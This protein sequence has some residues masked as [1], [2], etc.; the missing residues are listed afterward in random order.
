[1]SALLERARAALAPAYRVDGVLGVGGVGEVFRA[2]DVQL[3]RPVAVKVLRPEVATAVAV[4]R[5]VREAR[6]LARLAHPHIV[7]V[8]SAGESQGLYYFVMELQAGET[9][10]TRLER[11]PLPPAEAVAV[12]RQLLAA[13]GAAHGADVI[14]RDV[15]PSNVFLAPGGA[16]LGDFGIAHDD[17][18]PGLT[19]TGD[20]MGTVAYMAPEQRAGLPATPRT[21]L[22]GVGA[23]LYECLTGRRWVATQGDWSLVPERVKPVL[24]RALEHDAGAR[25]PGARAF[26][27]A[28]ERAAM[29]PDEPGVAQGKRR[30]WLTAAAILLVPALIVA[31]A[32]VL[33]RDRTR[34][35]EV[36]AGVPVAAAAV[37]V[38]AVVALLPFAADSSDPA[39]AVGR[40]LRRRLAEAGVAL[41]ADS[42]GGAA[43]L[44]LVPLV[45]RGD[46]GLAVRLSARGAR[47]EMRD[48]HVE[49]RG[50]PARPE[51]LGDSLA[52]DALLELW[53][54]ENSDSLPREALP[55]RLG[56]LI[57]WAAAERHFARAEWGDAAQ[58][59]SK[60]AHEDPACLICEWRLQLIARWDQATGGPE[61]LQRLAARA[62]RFPDPFRS[63]IRA[64]AQPFPARIDSLE[65]VRDR[66]PRDHLA[67]FLLGDE[68][69]HRGPLA[70]RPRRAALEAFATAAALRP[71]F[72]PAFE[73]TAWLEIADGDT[74]AARQSFARYAAN[75]NDDPLA[76]GIA[77]LLQ[78]ALTWRFAGP[79][80]G[81]A[82]FDT[83]LNHPLL[84][85]SPRI[86]T[87][88][89]FLVSFGVPDAALELAGRFLADP[90]FAAHRSAAARARAFAFAAQGRPDS[91][92]AAFATLA[93]P[94]EAA[95]WQALL[96]AALSAAD[97][98]DPDAVRLAAEYRPTLAALAADHRAPAGLPGQAALLLA[99]LGDAPARVPAGPS[100]LLAEADA[101]ARAGDPTG[102][103]ARTES[104]LGIESLPGTFLRAFLHLRRGEWRMSLGDAEQARREWVWHENLDV[105]GDLRGPPV[106]A[107]VD[108]ALGTLARWRRAQA[109]RHRTNLRDDACRD[110]AEVARL[111]TGGNATARA[112]ADSAR[113]ARRAL[114]C[115]AA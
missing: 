3:A 85:Q 69:M 43:D 30:A 105:E 110:Y 40:R 41:G 18:D 13:L 112:R 115:G 96:A 90:A 6:L 91:A 5:F 79:V 76:L 2:T 10:A 75:L 51:A 107:E 99:L 83:L 59:Y 71:R 4:E 1:M 15:K 97:P 33:L 50:D 80:P 72:L 55:R 22:Y 74:A 38:V 11:G 52:A 93:D 108:W 23:V 77:A 60:A 106:P 66:F 8:H 37:P 102:A 67:Q 92:V 95:R 44:T 16:R 48:L 104:L 86:G 78:S 98:G 24:R 56:A 19:R 28:L 49:R 12:A 88:P 89:R 36:S 64:A 26:A 7:P 21:D 34:V 58:A 32:R 61:G 20:A 46:G 101:I 103:L 42:A 39:S 81:R 68:L 57:A 62:D 14:H 84:R 111:W 65:A 113:A 9:L 63:L 94:A 70:G 17:S 114:S 27:T 25:W 45:E 100:R 54:V 53:R 73:H 82:L 87:A 47:G 31:L 109:A 29:L 35:A